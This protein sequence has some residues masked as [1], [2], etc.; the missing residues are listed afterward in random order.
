M[1]KI[2]TNPA[3]HLLLAIALGLCAGM[4]WPEQAR[5]LRPVGE[6]FITVL[7]WLML[8]VMCCA[9]AH[10]VASLRHLVNPGMASAKALLCF[11]MVSALALLTGMAVAIV[12]RPGEGLVLAAGAP[13]APNPLVVGAGAF[14]LWLLAASLAAGTALALAGHAGQRLADGIGSIA[15]AGFALAR[16]IVRIAPLIA[17]AGVASTVGR[18]GIEGLARAMDLLLGIYLGTALFMALVLGALARLTGFSLWRFMRAIADALLLAVGTASSLAAMPRLVDKL[19]EAGC[20]P[21]AVRVLV[22]AGY[23]FNLGGSAVY[24]GVALPFLAQVAHIPLGAADYAAMF[25][26]GL[27]CSRTASP[28]NGSAFM[29]VTSAV[30]MLPAMPAEGMV[31]LFSVERLMKCRPVGNLVSVGV[32]CMAIAAWT[33]KLDRSRL[34]RGLG[35]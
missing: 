24:L 1:K 13:V 20:A 3:T 32:S 11:T 17:F 34:E 4:A 35:R 5:Q 28:M 27:L 23:A 15:T 9:V 16:H 10:G 18:H 19:V 22:P 29:T 7:R 8:P 14:M 25:A 21:E 26:I 12:L 6:S 30:A 2:L 31:L 33:G